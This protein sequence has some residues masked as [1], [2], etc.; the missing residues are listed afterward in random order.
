MHREYHGLALNAQL[1]YK[2]RNALYFFVKT[3]DHYLKEV[4]APPV[5]IAALFTTTKTW[6]QPVS[7]N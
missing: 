3:Y 6:K 2:C 1:A 4:S 7:V 5:F